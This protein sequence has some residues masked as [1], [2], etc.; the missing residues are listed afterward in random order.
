M[1]L[2]KNHYFYIFFF[3]TQ[4]CS[5]RFFYNFS[6]TK[7]LPLFFYFSYLLIS[8]IFFIFF[9]KTKL[10]IQIINS[11]KVLFA[12]III[13]STY[14]FYKYPHSIGTERDDCYLIIL[15]NLANFQFPYSKTMLGDPCSTGLST[16]IFYFPSFF[17]KNFF[18]F[19]PTI[20]LI[21]FY[22]LFKKIF[23]GE[24][25][26]FF[27]YLQIFNLLY[28]E[29][30]IGGSDFFLISISYLGGILLLDDY[31]K[32]KKIS[33]LYLAFIFLF[34]FYGSRI[35]FIYLIPLNYLIFKSIYKSKKFD[36]F[37][38][39]QFFLTVLLILIP[40]II[41]PFE[42]HP[43]HLIQKTYGMIVFNFSKEILFLIITL[44]VIY[45]FLSRKVNLIKNLNELYLFK[46]ALPTQCIV[47]ILPLLIIITLTFLFRLTTDAIRNW[48]GLSYLILIY[49]CIVFLISSNFKNLNIFKGEQ[50]EKNSKKKI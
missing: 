47:Y 7:E 19:T 48:E 8:G 37:Y 34:F 32:N 12:T 40:L 2:T 46:K 10:F 39:F 5:I 24:I 13:F 20:Y 4:I 23:N 18:S 36:V 29:E 42:Y 3:L 11:K 28:L 31:F 14:I 41:N 21:L 22:I 45:Y 9:L 25:V 27:I 6:L 15:E 26:N 1:N 30:A 49:P 35:I 17:F 50:F 44:F 33:Y 43:A 38:F 16:L